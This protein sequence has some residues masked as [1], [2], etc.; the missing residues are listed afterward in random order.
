M[1]CVALRIR[2]CARRSFSVSGRAPGDPPVDAAP[3]RLV[4][5]VELVEDD[6]TEG[7]AV[8]APEAAPS[9]GAAGFRDCVPAGLS[10]GVAAG[11]PVCAPVG[12]AE[13]TAAG[14]PL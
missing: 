3:A 7:G 6:S 12:F 1:L 9:G 5:L 8:L 2:S 14:L 4:R 11:L 13:G 10:D